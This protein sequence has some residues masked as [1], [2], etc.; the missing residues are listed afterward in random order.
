M[1]YSLTR[2]ISLHELVQSNSENYVLGKY[3]YSKHLCPVFWL[4][5]ILM[6]RNNELISIKKNPSDFQYADEQQSVEKELANNAAT[7]VNAKHSW[8]GIH[9]IF[10]VFIEWNFSNKVFFIKH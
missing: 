9:I 10:Q 6:L 5:E 3:M 7:T 2:L 8:S 1:Q 4:R